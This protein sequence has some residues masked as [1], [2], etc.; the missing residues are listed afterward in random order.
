MGVFRPIRLRVDRGSGRAEVTASRE[1]V[2]SWGASHE[3]GGRVQSA[4]RI[5]VYDLLEPEKSLW[6]SG[7]VQSGEQEAKYAGEPLPQG[8]R[9]CWALTL[10]DDLGLE[11]DVAEGEFLTPLYEEWRAGWIA[12]EKDFEGAAIYFRREF[13]VRPGLKNA[14]L[15]CCGIGYQYVTVNGVPAECSENGE[16]LL[17]PV[18]SD[19]SR[20]CLYSV[21]PLNGLL[22]DG[23]N[24][25][26]AVVA[27]GWRDNVFYEGK[28]G[29]TDPGRDA[30][31]FMGRPQLTAQLMLEYEDGVEWIM[32]DGSWQCAKGGVTYAD[33]FKGERFDERLEPHG[34]DSFGYDAAGFEAAAEVPS[35]GGRLLPASIEPIVEQRRYPA[36]T[37][38]HMGG[39]RY[40]VDFGVNIAGWVEL[41]VPEGL[42]PGSEITLI[43][44]EELDGEETLHTAN[45]RSADQRDVY[46]TDGEAAVWSP[47]FTYHGFRWVSVEGLPGLDE[48][49]IEAV[50]I[51]NDVDTGSFFECG[52][53]LANAI[54]RIVLQTERDNI[55][56]ILTDCPQR[57]ERQG[58]MNDATVRFEETPYN[59]D[60]GRIFPKIISDIIDAQSGDGAITCTAPFV[61][62]GRPADP[63]CSSF[64]VAGMQNLMHRGDIE[65]V[66]RAYPAFR[67]WNECL[68]SLAAENGG[69][70]GLTRYGDWAGPAD[71]CTDPNGANSAVTPGELMSTGFHFHNYRLL[72]EM[73]RRLGMPEE[74]EKQLEGAEKVREAF[75]KKWWDAESG[76]VATGSQACQAFALWLGILP[77]QGRA[78][79]ARRMHEAVISA[80]TRITTGNL[81][82]R[83]LLDMLAEYGYTDTAWELVTREEYPSW[84]YML[85]NGATTVWERFELKEDGGMNSHNHPMYGALG[86]WFYAYLVGVKPTEPGWRRFAV[87]PFIP[88]KLTFAEAKVVTVSGDVR[89]KWIKRYGQLI[90]TVDVP[91]GCEADVCFGGRTETVGAGFHKFTA[92]L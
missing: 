64:L 30:V 31:R 61:F 56:H 29:V 55:H 18:F 47:R 48:S 67:A 87:K 70:V 32:T 73:A 52:S 27:K 50:S 41:A 9:L 89:V 74:A 36:K 5:S 77:E 90:L 83:Y 10:R 7:W 76:T 22:N 15:F 1:P 13:T 28:Y 49:M 51:Y 14:V 54:Q 58:W 3:D 72:A 25:I 21:I 42:A 88:E 2:F 17:Q 78:L 33:I 57:D 38:T 80:G 19:Y 6:E 46:I 91:F 81:C 69:I 62:G 34:F 53:M 40:I 35:P 60:T 92:A 44:A 20:R 75:L 86:Y 45:L 39:G 24:C 11:S 82:T 63:V 43:H 59:F 85:Q 37:V 23:G 8:R 26:G 79:A 65:T 12:P 84:G 4:W 71:C 66:R 68:A 16:A